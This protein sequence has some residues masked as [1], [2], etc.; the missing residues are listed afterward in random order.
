VPRFP[1]PAAIPPQAGPRQGA[2]IRFEGARPISPEAPAAPSRDGLDT[3]APLSPLRCL[4]TRRSGGACPWA[5]PAGGPS[6][7]RSVP[8]QRTRREQSQEGSSSSVI[9][10]H[11]GPTPVLGPSASGT[12]SGPRSRSAASRIGIWWEPGG[13]ATSSGSARFSSRAL[14]KRGASSRRSSAPSATTC[15]ARKDRGVK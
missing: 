4:A 5:A 1:G 9:A 2:P 15:G 11:S 12:P 8:G 6:A 14:R 7:K 3:G 13:G 10:P